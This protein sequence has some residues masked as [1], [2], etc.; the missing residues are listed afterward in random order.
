MQTLD[1]KCATAGIMACAHSPV[2]RVVVSLEALREGPL[3][4]AV[5]HAKPLG[6]QAIVRQPRPLLATALDHHV[7]QFLSHRTKPRRNGKQKKQH[8]EKKTRMDSSRYACTCVYT[9]QRKTRFKKSRMRPH[10][11]PWLKSVS[12]PSKATQK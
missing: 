3:P 10:R 9:S 7:A 4:A 2:D 1:D 8:K 11:R 6:D 12:Q 5:H